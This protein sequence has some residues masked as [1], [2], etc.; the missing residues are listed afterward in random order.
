MRQEVKEIASVVPAV[1][2]K[3]DEANKTILKQED[4]V[5][6]E[7]VKLEKVKVELAKEQSKPAVVADV[8]K[9]QQLVKKLQQLV[10]KLLRQEAKVEKE[11][12]K[13]EKTVEK[14]ADKVEKVVQKVI[15]KEIPIPQDLPLLEDINGGKSKLKTPPRQGSPKPKPSPSPSP[16]M[17]SPDVLSKQRRELSKSPVPRRSTSNLLLQDITEA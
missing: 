12:K 6:K 16:F 5:K 4:E 3:V 15:E 10:K 7:A 8:K 2:K 17:I 11:V 13:L 14:E 9:E 1:A